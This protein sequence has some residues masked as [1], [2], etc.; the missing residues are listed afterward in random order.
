MGRLPVHSAV[1]K[2]ASWTAMF[3]SAAHRLLQVP[4]EYSN[5][6]TNLEGAE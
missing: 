5:H 6:S 2:Q 3:S 1:G 4:G